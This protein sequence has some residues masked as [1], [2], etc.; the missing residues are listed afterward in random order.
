MQVMDIAELCR[1]KREGMKSCAVNTCAA[2]MSS[3]LPVPCVSIEPSAAL[4]RDDA[5]ARCSVRSVKREN[6]ES[7]MPKRKNCEEKEDP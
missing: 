1:C 4:Y 7:R 2:E 5:L 6:R 3:F